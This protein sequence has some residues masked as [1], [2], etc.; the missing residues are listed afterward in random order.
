MSNLFLSGCCAL[1]LC[2]AAGRAR[3]QT[4]TP[5]AAAVP[6]STTSDRHEVVNEKDHHFLGRVEFVRGDTTIFA[7]E[8]WYYSDDNRFIAAGNVVFSQGQNRIAADRADFDTKTNL[9]TFYN[10]TGIASV[11]PQRQ[12]VRAG[13]VAPPPVANQET[14][15]Y[16]FGDTIEK[17]G[18]KKYR[19]TNGG[20]TTCVQ[21]TPRWDL[22][23]D[24]VVLNVDHY[25]LL[26]NAVL[27][28]KGVPM[29][30]VPVLLYPTKKEDRATGF[31]IPGYGS[32]T[33]LGQ[34][35]HNAFFWA[36][37]RSQ[38]ATVMHEW[39]SKAGQGVTGEYR[40]NF[41]AGSDGNITT[42][43]V[44]GIPGADG[45]VTPGGTYE[46]RGGA[47]QLLPGGLRARANIDYFSSLAANQIVNNNIY[48]ISQNRR[49]YGGNVVGAWGT[50][51]LNA[52]FDRSEYFYAG[53]NSSGVTGGA[54]RVGLTRN[55]RP[56]LGS[57]VYFSVGSE[58]VHILNDRKSPDGAGPAVDTD[59]GLTRFDF[60]PQIRYPFK[61]W[62]W[63]TVN[64]SVGWRDTYYTRSQT[65][66]PDLLAP[67]TVVD[68]PINRR[69]FTAQSQI[70]GPVFNRIWDTPGSGY[71]EKFKHSIEPSLLIQTT[72]P[73][74]NADRVVRF[75]GTD[76]FFGGTQLTYGLTNRFFAKRREGRVAAA[77]EIA[78]VEVSQS[79][80]TNQKQ[81][82]VDPRYGTSF[83]GAAA[84]PFSAIAISVRTMPTASVN[85]TLRA[86]LDSHDRSLRTIS[87]N[88]AYTI[89]G[90]LQTNVGWSKTGNI[91]DPNGV[92]VPKTGNHFINATSTLHTRDNRYGGLY[93]FSY[94]VQRSSMLNQRLS[95]YY[96]AQCCGLAFEYQ[97]Y[98]LGGFSP[99][100]GSDH[101]FF[102]SFT[103]AGLG[104]FSPFS[105]ANG[106]V[107]R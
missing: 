54:P 35:I 44:S 42:H 45:T 70:V 59:L 65:P 95:G 105:G 98:G 88:A 1:I 6:E 78:D 60:N 48:D 104:N 80:Y 51:S 14:D 41:G 43:Y 57:Q 9:G 28:V 56:L 86:E 16:F 66:D 22:H 73:I 19:I 91:K 81:S 25:T 20:F 11:K 4:P 17:I 64:S 58:F 3:A 34:Q 23:A 72:S 87:A 103:L 63:F 18:P 77:R 79:Y 102:L 107:P 84:S 24:T 49:S 33:V 8:A 32:S 75:D 26:K 68:Q 31:L 61:K 47:N 15:V 52:T 97:V 38:D 85:A 101:R 99:V 46:L 94:D 96:S 12:Q 10:A 2:A 106:G 21:P 92:I 90:L 36:I 82:Q 27:T 13:A 67:P 74:D 50:Y 7:E 29:L 30:Y 55:E 5:P 69:F 76:T 100:L 53:N 93:A 39:Y 71:A 37:S 83:S 62:Q 40:Y 89:T